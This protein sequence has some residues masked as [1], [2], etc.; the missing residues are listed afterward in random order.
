MPVFNPLGVSEAFVHVTLRPTAAKGETLPRSYV[1]STGLSAPTSG[2]LQLHAIPLKAGHTLSTI[3]FVS[4]GTALA[5]GTNQWF[6]LYDGALNLLRV[7]ND[8]GATAWAANSLKT[9]TLASSYT[10]PVDGLYYVGL[11][12]VATTVPTLAG[13]FPPGAITGAAPVLSYNAN[14]GLTNPASAPATATNLASQGP[15]AYAYVG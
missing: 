8:D 4:G 2:R 5:T 3:T 10:V 7:T 11:T 9:L 14:T 1:S 13:V 6:S 15:R 12:I